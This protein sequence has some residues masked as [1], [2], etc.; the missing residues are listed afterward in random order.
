MGCRHASAAT[1][2]LDC[3]SRGWHFKITGVESERQA[4]MG[5]CAARYGAATQPPP[6]SGLSLLEPVD[7]QIIGHVIDDGVVERPF[8]H[9]VEPES[10]A[11]TRIYVVF[12]D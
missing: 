11:L 1:D 8:A 10:A 12:A 7:R 3:R 2:R 4:W 6:A 5:G 9:G